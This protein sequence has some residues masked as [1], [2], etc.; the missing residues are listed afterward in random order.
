MTMN[1]QTATLNPAQLNALQQHIA[2]KS[3]LMVWQVLLVGLW[4]I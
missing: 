4:F 1:M 2:Q 3:S